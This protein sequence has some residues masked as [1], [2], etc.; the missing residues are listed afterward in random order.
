M[1]KREKILFKN[2]KK[3]QIIKFTVKINNNC[4]PY[5]SLNKKKEKGQNYTTSA[6]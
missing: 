2:K 6:N 4:S 3:K 1:I 5:S